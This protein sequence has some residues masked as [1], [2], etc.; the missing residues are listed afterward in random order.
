M[1]LS[2]GLAVLDALVEGLEGG[3]DRRRIGGVGEGG[4]GEAGEGDGVL[5]AGRLLHDLG[6]PL[7][8][9]VGARQGGAVGQLDH[10]DGVALVQRRDE[11]ARHVVGDPDGAGEQAR[12][13]RQHDQL[14]PR[15]RADRS[16]VAVRGRVEAAVEAV[17]Q[18]RCRT[19]ASGLRDGS[20][21]CGLSSNAA[22][23]GD[24]VSELKAEMRVETAMVRANCR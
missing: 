13:D 23:A 17:G 15:Q 19:G 7:H 20:W 2:A 18:A 24:K 10:D 21:L 5:H 9:R 8:D 12:I 4:A 16:G 14:V 1:I 3:E 6:G 11:A 22:S